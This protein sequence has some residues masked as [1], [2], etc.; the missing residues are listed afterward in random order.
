MPQPRPWRAAV[1]DALY[2]PDGFY[3]QPA[4]PARHFRT[5]AHASTGLA[6]AVLVL[7]RAVDDA[8]GRPARLDL[9]DVGAGRGELLDTVRRL[10]EPALAARTALLAVEAATRPPGLAA[11]IGWS[12]RLPARV[13]GLLL[14]NEWLDVVP[15]DV[16]QRTREGVRLVLVDPATGVESVGGEP[17][18]QDAAWLQRWWP[19]DDQPVG[20]RA[21]V[22]RPRDAAW[23][24]VVA[25]LD[26]G[27]AVA[28]DY[29]HGLDQRASG[30]FGAGTLAGYRDGRRVQPIPDGSCDVTAHVALDACAAVGASAGA[31]ATVLTNQRAA[32][33]ALGL[34][35][36]APD[37]ALARCDPVGYRDRLARASEAAELVDPGG[38]GGFGWLVHAVGI[39]LP[40]AL[41]S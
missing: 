34:D 41:T 9:V 23:A 16:A 36:R 14:A 5:S 13:S 22:G 37:P 17:A 4:G 18:P 33:L 11:D 40:A 31:T 12:H 2:G 8:L 26:R 29:A 20:S 35:P 3:R 39:P 10:A 28:S 24:S 7:L 15:V 30:A 25:R 21:E 6:V 19:L 1:D 32:L 38:L 27:L